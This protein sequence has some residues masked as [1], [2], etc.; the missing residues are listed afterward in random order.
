MQQGAEFSLIKT[1]NNGLEVHQEDTVKRK[2]G[3]ECDVTH[4]CTSCLG[5]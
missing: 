3:A 2:A 5:D 1:Q 4:V